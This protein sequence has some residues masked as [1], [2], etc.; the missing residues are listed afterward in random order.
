MQ[1]KAL[2]T[3]ILLSRAEP[4]RTFAYGKSRPAGVRISF[5]F[6]LADF[7]L[8]RQNHTCQQSESANYQTIR[9]IIGAFCVAFSFILFLIFNVFLLCQIW[10]RISI[11]LYFRTCMSFCLQHICFLF[12]VL[13]IA[14]NEHELMCRQLGRFAPHSQVRFDA[15]NH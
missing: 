12:V 8:R 6:Y 4:I 10:P 13:D 11:S 9:L 5:R 14:P 3:S 1:S 7:S 15:C 2:R